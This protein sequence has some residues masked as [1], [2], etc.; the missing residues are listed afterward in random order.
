MKKT[1][2]NN[3]QN[4]Q[5]IGQIVRK[6][7]SKTY[8]VRVDRLVT[9]PKYLKKFKKSRNFLV[10]SERE[11]WPIGSQVKIVPCKKISKNK[12]WRIL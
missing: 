3:K 11:D 10:H 7:G 5:L 12:A 1:A 4:K 2:N 9:H 6:S 8:K